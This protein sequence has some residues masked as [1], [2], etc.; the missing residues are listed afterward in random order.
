MPVWKVPL[1]LQVKIMNIA[2]G[3]GHI[4][5]LTDQYQL[6]TWG[7]GRRGQLGHGNFVSKQVSCRVHW[8]Q[9]G[10]LARYSRYSPRTS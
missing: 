10:M 7:D 6:L 1:S 9:V 3:N 4:A 5:L 2:C 8:E